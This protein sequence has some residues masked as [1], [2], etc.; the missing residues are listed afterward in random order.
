MIA[1][2]A[3]TKFHLIFSLSHKLLHRKETD[4][5]LFLYSGLAGVEEYR[6]KILECNIYKEVY[7]VNEI[8]LRKGWAGVPNEKAIELIEKDIDLIVGRVENWLPARLEEMD[9]IYIAN[10]HWALGMYCIHNHIPY[11]YYEDG[12][13]MLSKP[14]Y[15]YELVYKLNKTQAYIAKYIGAFG[16]NEYVIKKYADLNNQTEGFYDEKACHYSVKNT[17]E[18]LDESDMKNVLYIFEAPDI[19]AGNEKC[20]LVFTEHFI[21]MKRLPIE[22]QT[23][24][25]TLLCDYF[26]GD[27]KLLIKPHPSDVHTNYE[28]IFPGVSVIS[29]AFP[30]EL[31]PFCMKAEKDLGLAA[32]STAVLGLKDYFNRIVRFDIDIENTYSKFHKYYAIANFVLHNKLDVIQRLGVQETQ[33]RQFLKLLNINCEDEL[34]EDAITATIVDDLSTLDGI[35]DESVLNGSDCCIFTQMPIGKTLN[36]EFWRSCKKEK[37]AIISIKKEC[38]EDSYLLTKENEYIYIYAKD[39]KI[40]KKVGGMTIMKDLPYSGAK[41]DIETISGDDYVKIKFLEA[42]LDSTNKKLQYYIEREQE[43]INELKK[44]K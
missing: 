33:L 10:D 36:H 9:E 19:D 14:D 35:I 22:G 15:S 44:Y 8:E 31:L 39:P 21:N 1:Y 43:L 18:C 24:I 4:A 3:M 6:T 17:L 7:I 16:N 41:I 40:I 12:V 30:S 23:E 38:A 5:I 34:Q 13:G 25:Y 26:S 2:Y 37:L 42:V 32:C 11:Y 27:N 28:K 20:T 29:R